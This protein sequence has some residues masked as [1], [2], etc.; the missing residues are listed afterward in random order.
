MQP[1]CGD[2][3]LFGSQ[4]HRKKNTYLPICLS[5]W[6]YYWYQLIYI[7]INYTALHCSPLPFHC[8]FVAIHY[9]AL[10]YRTHPSPY[11]AIYSR[12]FPYMHECMIYIYIHILYIYGL[13]YQTGASANT[14]VGIK[15]TIM[16][17]N[18]KIMEYFITT[19]A[20]F[21]LSTR[22]TPK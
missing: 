6:G 7:F 11:I 10:P 12:T 8:R 17:L 3:R 21:V 22:Y 1:W 16:L 14:N 19:N 20:G 18:E 15:P 13:V 9:N 4:K 2:I 5:F